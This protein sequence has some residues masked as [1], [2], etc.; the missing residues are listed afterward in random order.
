M[1]QDLVAAHTNSTFC[2]STLTSNTKNVISLS[3]L[4]QEHTAKDKIVINMLIVIIA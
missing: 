2:N 4:L 1:T 3:Y